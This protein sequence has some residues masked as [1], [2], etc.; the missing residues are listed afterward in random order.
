VP[1]QSSSAKR[2]DV[3][4]ECDPTWTD[5]QK[6]QMK[7]KAR[8]MNEHVEDDGWI[9]RGSVPEDLRAEGD[10]W[11]AKFASQW[12]NPSPGG[13]K[14][15]SYSDPTKQSTH[16]YHP[17][18][19]NQRKPLQADHVRE[20]QNGGDPKGPFLW[21]DA[22]VNGSSGSQIRNSGRTQITGFKTKNCGTSEG[23]DVR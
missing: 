11:A 16:F 13:R 5:C 21:L 20:I 3:T 12:D 23:G 7:A 15:P 4:L 17:C 22:A 2:G 8:K 19:E 18:A 10:S 9:N 1:N 14:W 6:N